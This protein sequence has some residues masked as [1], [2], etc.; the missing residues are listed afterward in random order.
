MFL[1]CI[2][3]SEITFKQ[4]NS[5]CCLKHPKSNVTNELMFVNISVTMYCVYMLEIKCH[6][7]RLF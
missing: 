4:N 7:V 3:T 1:N 6:T 2:L 5:A